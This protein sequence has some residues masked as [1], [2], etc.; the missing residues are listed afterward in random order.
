MKRILI[1]SL[2]IFICLPLALAV[3]AAKTKPVTLE[4]IE[5]E[6]VVNGKPSRV[7]DVIQP[8]GTFGYTGIRGE[9][10]DVTV[11]NKTHVPLALHWHGIVDPNTEDGVPYV[12]QLPIAPGKSWH[13][14][15]R[16]KQAGTYWLHSHYKL[17]EQKLMAAPLI[18]HEPQA[19][20]EKEAL[21]FIQDFT[22]G[23]PRVIFEKLQSTLKDQPAAA[24]SK[25]KKNAM[26]M[27]MSGMAKPD[28]TDVKFDAYLTNHRTLQNPEIVRVKPKETIRLR[29]INASASSNYSINLGSLSGK[30]IAV[31]GE[32]IQPVTGSRFQI[33]I[34]DRLDIRVTLPAG[35]HA[36]PI[37]ALPEGTRQQT[38]LIL[39]TAKA[40]LPS[41]PE[42]TA[43]ANPAL[44]YSQELKTVTTNPM[45]SRPVQQSL[46]YTLGGNM[47]TYTWTMNGQEWPDIKPYTV[48]PDQRTE[49]VF[50]NQ[51]GM[52]H[53]MHLHGH[54]FQ[55]SEIN[56]K[57]ITGRKGDTINVMPHSTVKVIFD[58]ANPGIWMLH[59]H[60][61]YHLA[62]GMMTTINYDGYPD[63]F[64][65]KQR[66][67]GENL[68]EQSPFPQT[69]N[70]GK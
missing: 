1:H 69:G 67:E 13:Y 4:V 48:K 55:I 44:D 38:G 63:R 10:F 57:K 27:N 42:T 23:D 68:Y 59:C 53:P 35:E 60:I 65:A 8:D 28:L 52:A 39:A 58:T 62:G 40:D 5:K 14:Q 32:P 41:L 54:V 6:L 49:L 26:K 64:T 3:H 24:Q 37:L 66:K 9:L 2:A 30:L 18:I 17:Q 56:G 61:L 19:K 16:L 47:S 21:M 22:F 51:T 43:Q 45:K 31:D 20:P 46:P 12:T 70:A 34:G 29:I 7:F 33:P 36:Y 25:D 50:V 11:K 15:F